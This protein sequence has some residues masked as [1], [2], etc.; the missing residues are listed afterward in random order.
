MNKKILSVL[1]G[2]LLLNSMVIMSALG[3][4]TVNNNLIFI[5]PADGSNTSDYFIP[6]YYDVTATDGSKCKP[7]VLQQGV[8]ATT[9]DSGWYYFIKDGKKNWF[10]VKDSNKY[11]IVSTSNSRDK[12]IVQCSV[13]NSSTGETIPYSEFSL[14]RQGSNVSLGSYSTDVTGAFSINNLEAGDYYLQQKSVTNGLKL[15]CNQIR[16][17]IKNT[18][19]SV[20]ILVENSKS[21]KD[22]KVSIN[23]GSLAKELQCGD[24]FQLEQDSNDYLVSLAKDNI[25]DSKSIKKIVTDSQHADNTESVND[26]E[27]TKI[28]AGVSPSAI[29]NDSNATTESGVATAP[30]AGTTGSAI[31]SGAGVV[32]DTATG[33]AIGTSTGSAI[34][35]QPTKE[36]YDS[37][38]EDPNDGTGTVAIKCLDANNKVI[39]KHYCMYISDGNIINNVKS[40]TNGW[41]IFSKLK[42][43]KYTFR[44]AADKYNTTLVTLDVAENKVVEKKV[45]LSEFTYK[46]AGIYKSKQSFCN[47]PSKNGTVI[48]EARDTKGNILNNFKVRISND[49]YEDAFVDLLPTEKECKTLYDLDCKSATLYELNAPTGF[50]AVDDTFKLTNTG[51]KSYSLIIV[52]EKASKKD[53]EENKKSDNDD[54]YDNDT[55]DDDSQYHDDEDDT[56]TDDYSNDDDGNYLPKTGDKAAPEL[57]VLLMFDLI[58]IFALFRYQKINKAR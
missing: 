51:S 31:S 52:H 27:N 11:T 47:F 23:S 58:V 29:I 13:I 39:K 35:T 22:T 50:K 34:E 53:D 55:S 42:P 43:G 38:C 14:Y 33:D 48:I 49:S 30:N 45:E 44:V 2:L 16:F 24:S 36:T 17:S 10:E 37:G 26:T 54:S 46:K 57:I 18:T 56:P 8:S 1:T 32:T 25:F 9:V 4:E 3:K 7:V 19:T 6:E 41:A 21:D 15:F 28:L 12:S 40:G 20:N 5:N